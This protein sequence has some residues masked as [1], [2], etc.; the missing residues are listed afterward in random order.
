MTK[1]FASRSAQWPLFQ[2]FT[3]NF[4]DWAIDTVSGVKKTL[5]CAVTNTGATNAI[6]PATLGVESGLTQGTDL[7]FDAIPMPTGAMIIG[8]TVYVETAFNGTSTAT[9]STGVAGATTAFTTTTDLKTAGITAFTLTGILAKRCLAGENIRLTFALATA[10]Q[11]AGKV[12]IR[13]E[14]TMDGRANENIIN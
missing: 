1:K 12:R 3:M 14:Y 6:D 10:D 4:N 2:E 5:G 13:V 9:V 8:G 7:V 11:T